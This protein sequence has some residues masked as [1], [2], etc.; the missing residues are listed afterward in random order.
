[1]QE[2][3]EDR[4]L[5]EYLAALAGNQAAP[6]GGSAAGV[7]GALAA[8]LAEMMASLTREPGDDLL[9]AKAALA[10][11]RERALAC[12]RN[13]E[14]S[15]GGYIQALAMPKSTPEEKATRKAAM[16]AAMEQSARVPLALAVVAIEIVNALEAVIRDG[17][18]TVLGDAEA[19]LVLAQATVDICQINVG[20]NLGY[21]KDE[22]LA[23]DLRTSIEAASEMIVH[24][25]AERRA[26]IGDR[27]AQG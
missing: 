25:A 24:L 8:C 10:E 3:V 18:K 9:A 11:L 27:R 19:S 20:A 22:A 26:Q 17:N 1:M 21:I 6:G 2:Q 13:D 14:L 15:Y 7:V 4:V 5:G 12:A 16:N 23:D